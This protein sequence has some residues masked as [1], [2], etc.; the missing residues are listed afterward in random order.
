MP[1]CSRH[2]APGVGVESL[3]EEQAGA[4]AEEEDDRLGHLVGQLPDTN[5]STLAVGVAALVV[6]AHGRTDKKHGGLTLAPATTQS[7]LYRTATKL[8]CPSPRTFHYTR[9]VP[10]PGGEGATTVTESDARCAG[11]RTKNG[12]Y[13]HGLVNAYRAVS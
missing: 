10:V 8:P 6:S 13:G 11:P 9:L 7:W 1:A 4:I 3:A 12:F 2:V 5:L